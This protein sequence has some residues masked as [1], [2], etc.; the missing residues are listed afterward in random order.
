LLIYY[1]TPLYAAGAIYTQEIENLD[2]NAKRKM[3][4]VAGGVSNE[5]IKKMFEFQ[6]TPVFKIIK[7][8]GT[9][10]RLEVKENRRARPIKKF[11]AKT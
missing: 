5:L 6:K 8:L 9:K 1:A 4:A 10:L 7:R 11:A 2:V 3:F